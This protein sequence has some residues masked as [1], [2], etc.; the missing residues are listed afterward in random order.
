MQNFIDNLSS[1][2]RYFSVPLF[3][4][5]S[6]KLSLMSFITALIIFYVVLKLS[7]FGENL[8]K[9]LLKKYS[10][11]DNGVKDSIATFIRYTILVIG[12]LI[13]LDTIG[14]SMSSLAA[15]GAVL[16]VGIGFGLQNITQNFISGLII[17][18]ERPIKV[19]DLVEVGGVNGRIIAIGA[20]STQIHTRDDVAII[21][22]N[23]QFI[24]EQVVNQSYSGENIRLK[25]SVGV[26]Y[27]SDPAEVEKV[28]MNVVKNQPEVLKSP[29]PKV[30]FS[31]FADSSLNF[32]LTIWIRDQWFDERIKSDIRFKIFEAFKKNNIQIPFP[33]MDVHLNPNQ[34]DL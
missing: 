17:L 25:I 1:V 12:I 2:W 11:L 14:I 33:Q 10:H 19:G 15:V 32:N 23:S 31:D 16:M 20:R 8:T 21:I 13:T 5:G 26:S 30:F 27:S 6:H 9:R 24:S 34:K 3:E 28:L 4:I 7:R 22:P 29:E 18:L